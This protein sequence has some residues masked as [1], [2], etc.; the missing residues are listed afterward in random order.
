VAVEVATS[1]IAF[2]L[3]LWPL[4]LLNMVCDHRKWLLL[5][6]QRLLLAYSIVVICAFNC[7]P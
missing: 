4:R 2:A 5:R 7:S 1:A 3:R 6:T